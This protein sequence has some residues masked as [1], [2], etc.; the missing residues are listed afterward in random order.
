ML[1]SEKVDF[2]AELEQIYATNNSIIV[3]KYHGLTV[4]QITNLRNSLSA[5]GGKFKVVKNTLA[6]IA[7]TNSK[8]DSASDMFKGPLAIVYSN[9]VVSL[10]REVMDFAKANQVFSVVGGII[11]HT[12]VNAAAIETISKLPSMDELRGK[13]VGLLQAPASG[14]ARV[15]A[16]PATQLARVLS[17]YSKN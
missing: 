11:N 13:I 9:E 12:V 3:A 1:R 10:S 6:K 8:C 16:A 5:S 4:K 15:I 14:L 17:V 7:V 2:V